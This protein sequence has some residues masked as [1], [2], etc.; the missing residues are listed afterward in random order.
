M[1]VTVKYKNR[2]VEVDIPD[3]KLEELIKEKQQT[4]YERVDKCDDNYYYVGY[5]GEI[6]IDCDCFM[7]DDNKTYIKG[8]YYTSKELAENIARFET[9]MR[10]IRRRAAEICKPIDWKNF[11]I[12]K[13]YIYFDYG[14]GKISTSYAHSIRGLFDILFDTEEHAKQIIEEFCDELIWY[15]TEYK[16]RMDG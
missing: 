3:E 11:N 14:T 16:E 12:P 9:L 6:D 4:G 1:K 2:E 13:W 5:C 7:A 8:N 10:R 15:F